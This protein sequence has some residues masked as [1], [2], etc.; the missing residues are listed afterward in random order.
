MLIGCSRLPDTL[1]QFN[2]SEYM[3]RYGCHIDLSIVV[4]RLSIPIIQSV[5]FKWQR[6]V[7]QKRC[8]LF[9]FRFEYKQGCHLTSILIRAGLRAGEVSGIYGIFIQANMQMIYVRW[10]D[11]CSYIGIWTLSLA[12]A[13]HQKHENKLQPA[14]NWA[15]IF[16]LKNGKT[17]DR[18][19]N[20][21]KMGKQKK[22]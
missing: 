18:K 22:T 21:Q 11:I 9:I 16:H 19:T 17:N 3:D 15:L 10:L 12:Y 8:H 1:S 13:R 4:Y 14:S 20:R 2:N 7:Q 6:S 5:I